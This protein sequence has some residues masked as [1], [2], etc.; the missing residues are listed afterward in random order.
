MSRPIVSRIESVDA[1][2]A[3]G[4]YSQAVRAG[5]FLYVS[6]QIPLTKN[7]LLL[8]GSIEEQSRQVMDNLRAVLQKAGCAFENV[9][10]TTIFLT[11]MGDFSKVN[12]VYAS[13][14]KEPFPARET[15]CV[16]S[17]P[18]GAAVEISMI[19]YKPV[20]QAFER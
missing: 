5:D 15:V 17:L 6:G 8:N 12:A 3:V 16:K 10:K 20:R 1:P 9:V 7:G 18:R 13:F 11:D 19:A 2:K 14:L 4:P